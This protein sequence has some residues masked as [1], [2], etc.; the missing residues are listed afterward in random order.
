MRIFRVLFS[1]ELEQISDFQICIIQEE[2]T[3]IILHYLAKN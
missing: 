1:H 2:V 3:V